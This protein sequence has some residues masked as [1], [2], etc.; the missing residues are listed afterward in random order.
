MPST[1]VDHSDADPVPAT[2]AEPAGS[3]IGDFVW[4]DANGDGLQDPDEAGVEGVDV[5][6]LDA[7][8]VELARDTTDHLGRYEFVGVV[9]GSYALEVELPADYGIT[10]PDQ[11]LDD[12]STR[13]SVT[14][15]ATAAPLAPTCSSSPRTEPTG[16]ISAWL[17]SR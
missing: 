11:G 9:D 1:D 5:V 10:Q 8:G 7:S 14:G 6:L 16:S 12:E 2:S 13:T 3:T 15:R 4:L 17:S